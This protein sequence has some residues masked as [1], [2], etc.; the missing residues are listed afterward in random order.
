MTAAMGVLLKVQSKSRE[1]VPFIPNETQMRIYR[2]IFRQQ[3]EGKPVRILELKGRQQGSSTGIGAYNFLRTICEPGTNSLIITEEK[4]GSA[5]NIF[6]MYRRFHQYLPLPV[7]TESARE[8]HLL[9]LAPPVGSQIKVEGEKNVTSYTFQ[10]VHLSEAAFFTNLSKT[11]AMLFQTVPDDP[12]TL[13]ILE[14]TANMA[15][16]DF[17]IEWTRAQEGKSDFSALFIPW[18]VHNEYKTPFKT[19]ASMKRFEDSVGTAANDM[20]GDERGLFEQYPEMSLESLNWRRSAIRNRT[21]GSI[22]EFMRQYPATAEE[23]FQASNNSIFDMG[24]LSRWLEKTVPA[25]HRGYFVSRNGE[26]HFEE[27]NAGIVHIWE[28]PH[29]YLEYVAGS[30]H[31]EG[32]DSGDYSCCLIFKRMPLQ[33]VAKIRGFDGRQ[34]PIDEF[35][36]QMWLMSLYYNQAYCCPE[37]N[38]DGGTVAHILRNEYTY[39]NLITEEMLGLF[40]HKTDRVGWRN[41]SATRRRVVARVQ[42]AIHNEEMIVYDE[43]LIRECQTFVA[44]NGRPQAMKKGKGRR[45]GEPEDGYYDDEVI[46]CGGCLLAHDALPLPKSSQYYES[47]HEPL[48]S[49]VDNLIGGKHYLDLV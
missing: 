1:L 40:A 26:P 49:D 17:A 42:E 5:S 9:K 24:V 11:L 3:E 28:E 15:G 22:S 35:A 44:V 36:E 33:L 19:E 27:D 32:L 10:M 14:T 6:S 13:I 34:V 18:Y 37:N 4:G 8:G 21:Q 25:G 46:A 12:S 47:K 23:A 38:A 29:L 30:D 31:A 20:Y 16:D 41:T 7:S 43:K 48:W 2:E 39:P 45:I